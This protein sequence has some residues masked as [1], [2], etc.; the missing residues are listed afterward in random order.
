MKMM[1]KLLKMFVISALLIWQT[2]LYGQELTLA[3]HNAK[4]GSQQMILTAQKHLK[5]VI[6]DI[7]N[8][9][10]VDFIYENSLLEGKKVLYAPQKNDN[11]EHLLVEVLS[12]VELS[13]KKIDTKV[14]AIVPKKIDKM[15]LIKKGNALEENSQEQAQFFV[16][17]FVLNTLSAKLDLTR[18]EKRI[19]GTVTSSE[20]GQPLP[21]VSILVKGTGTGTVTDAN[22]KYTISVP[23]NGVT[24]IFSYVG[25]TSQEIAVGSNSVVDVVLV[26]DVT[27]LEQ[28]VVVGYGSQKRETITGA[29]STVSA[30]EIV[31]LPVT[32]IASA[33]QGRVAGVSVT[34][35]GSPGEAPIVRIRGVG[36]ISYATNPLYVIDGFPTGDLNSFDTRDIESVEVLRDASAAA[37]YGSRASNGVILITTKK[38]KRNAKLSVNVDS[39]WGV[40]TAWKQLDLLKRDDYV[41]YASALLS[42]AGNALPPRFANLNQPIFAGSSQTFAQTDTDWQGAMFRSAAIRQHTVSVSGGNEKSRFFASGGYFK[43]D[44]IMLGTG[45]ERGNFRI[46]S[47]HQISKRINFGQNFTVSYDSKFNENNP[48][49]RTQI[50]NM[51]RMTPY[52]PIEDPNKLGGYGG[53]EGAD[54]SDPQ[55]PVR[56]AVQ[57][58]NNTQRFKFLGNAYIEIELAKS[59]RYKFTGGLDY[60]SARNYTFN[61]LYNEGFNSRNPASIGDGRD[62]YFSPIYTNQLTFEK[63]FGKHNINAVAVAERQEFR[64]IG[65]STGG[66]FASNTIRELSGTTNQTA[67]GSRSEEVLVSYLGRVNYDYA[68]K[69]LVSASI[70]RDGSSKFAPGNKWG[71]F[72]SVSVG[73]RINQEDFL[74]DVSQ[75]SE[76]KLRASYG[77]MGFNGIGNYAWQVAISPNAFPVLGG[78][79]ALGAYFDRLGNTDLKWEKTAMTN[80]GLDLGLFDNKITLA[81]EY[82]IR[83]TND[84]ILQ[85]PVANSLGYAQPPV[86]NI[87]SMENKGLEFVLGYNNK[88]GDLN[89]NATGNISFISNKVLSL[90]TENSSLFSGSNGDFGGFDITRTV[91]GESI[92]HFYGWKTAGIFQSQAEIDAAPKQPNA[93]PGDIRFVDSNGDG[94]ITADDRVSL[95]SFLPKFTYGANFSFNYKGFDLTLFLQGVSGN[96]IYNG[97]KVIGQGMLRLFNSQTDVLNAWTPSNTN[98]SVPRAV[99]GDP[100]Q[101]TR[102]SDRFL[103]SGSYLRIKNLVFGYAVPSSALDS[104]A[105]GSIKTA[106]LYFSAQNLLTITKYTGFDPEVGS[107]FNNTL[108]NGIDYGQFPQARTIMIGVQLGF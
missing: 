17:D 24:L 30:K 34:N 40:Q 80:I 73:W 72:P 52:I 81:A 28:V 55:N 32:N 86:V 106:R 59:L 67:S 29:I 57:D 68:G 62:T 69:Y 7:K 65:L 78:N 22:G 10:G 89:F 108:S 46:N 63:T 48:G 2:T 41:K 25:F 99:N 11:F 83:T 16:P 14:Y 85:Q 87:G 20:D 18:I 103:E 79:P 91:V 98:T 4:A 100:N 50:Q 49:G 13:Y 56:A 70:R 54:A 105:K 33:L 26:T 39:Y 1:Q 8:R 12:S 47:D 88:F 6:K 43:Q 15:G 82:Y 92:Q 84:L 21:G 64:Y 37:I 60:V 36:S 66:N 5:D 76:L 42:N 45:Y 35:N 77:T 58:I 19:T 93:K 44:G 53:A 31:T 3:R 96:Q 61:P 94:T 104:F 75:I 23:D 102:T 38:G 101:N 107:R 71:N 74:K 95:G 97:T 90:A 9:F 27:A 51:M